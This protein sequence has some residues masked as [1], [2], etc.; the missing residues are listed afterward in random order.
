[1]GNRN[2]R[3]EACPYCGHRI[4]PGRYPW[5]F[6]RHAI[7]GEDICEGPTGSLCV[8]SRNDFTLR[9]LHEIEDPAVLRAAAKIGR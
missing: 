6:R 4:A 9:L 3:F 8:G 7:T 5:R 2:R 1:M